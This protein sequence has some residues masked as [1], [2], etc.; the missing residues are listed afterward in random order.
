MVHHPCSYRGGGGS[1]D[2]RLK[3]DGKEEKAGPQPTQACNMPASTARRNVPIW[4]SGGGS[5]H[6]HCQRVP[7]QHGLSCASWWSWSPV[8]VADHGGWHGGTKQD[9][10]HAWCWWDSPTQRGGLSVTSMG[11]GWAAP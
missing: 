6:K 9:H 1:S 5:L 2:H 3:L 7:A 8:R 10:I 4:H 11:I